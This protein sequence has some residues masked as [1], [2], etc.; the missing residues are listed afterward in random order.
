MRVFLDDERNP[1]LHYDVIWRSW[2]DAV[3]FISRHGLTQI[4]HVSFD[5]DLGSALSGKDVAQL[6]VEYDMMTN[7]LP[8][9]FTF[10]VH[11]ANPIGKANI[12]SYLNN[13]L[14]A[15]GKSE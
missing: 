11:S 1:K 14:D 4:N 3:A 7:T 15:R 5:H 2:S 6:I 10:N 13:Y 12:E 8:K 9:D